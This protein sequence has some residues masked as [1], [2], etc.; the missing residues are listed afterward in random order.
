MAW[1]RLTLEMNT[2]WRVIKPLKIVSQ[3]LVVPDLLSRSALNAVLVT[4]IDGV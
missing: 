3:A 4:H 1:A 2:C